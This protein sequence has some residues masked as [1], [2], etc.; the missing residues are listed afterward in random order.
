MSPK[1]LSD[2]HYLRH[3]ILACPQDDDM[4]GAFEKIIG[5][6]NDKSNK[7]KGTLRTKFP[8]CNHIVVILQ[9]ARFVWELDGLH[10]QGP[11]C[12]RPVGADWTI[13]VQKRLDLWT[14]A[15]TATHVYNDIH[16]LIKIKSWPI[17]LWYLCFISVPSHTHSPLRQC[18]RG[19]KRKIAS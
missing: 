10:N 19:R 15:A 4:H 1:H 3:K 17:S 5:T 7:N 14:H 18:W 12:L 16:T 11:I 6:K 9:H 2:L 8:S 13:A